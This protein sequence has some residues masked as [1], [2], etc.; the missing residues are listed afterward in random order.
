MAHR[1]LDFMNPD[2]S[3]LALAQGAAVVLAT[4][5]TVIGVVGL[6]TD[7]DVYAE[8]FGVLDPPRPAPPTAKGSEVPK[9]A[10]TGGDSERSPGE[11]WIRAKASRDVALGLAA[12]ELAPRDAWQTGGGGLMP[13][14]ITV[15]TD[16]Y[17]AF[18]N[19]DKPSNAF[20]H[21][22]WVPFFLG[23]GG[24]LAYA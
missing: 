1:A 14:A 8:M 5:T 15:G 12:R 18:A 20:K 23:V 9:P 11:M 19:S 4:I 6:L 24:Y 2:F 17:L 16:G 10:V 13:S 22:V 21:A 3:T 7:G